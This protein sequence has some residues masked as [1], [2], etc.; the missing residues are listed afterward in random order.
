[1]SYWDN[2]K[3]YVLEGVLSTDDRLHNRE[4]QQYIKQIADST[5]QRF[6]VNSI[7]EQIEQNDKQL[8]VVTNRKKIMGIVLTEITIYPVRK[9]CCVWGLAGVGVGE[10]VD[11]VKYLEVWAGGLGC[12]GM[13]V[14]GRKGWVKHLDPLGFKQDGVELIKD[15]EYYGKI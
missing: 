1:M 2:Q 5:H 11:L 12:T 10:W 4:I 13:E 15:I 8:W 14:R 9:L 7:L 6:D 3:G